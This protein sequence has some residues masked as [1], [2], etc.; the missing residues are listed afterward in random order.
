MRD[1]LHRS[2]QIGPTKSRNQLVSL[3]STLGATIAAMFIVGALLL[4]VSPSPSSGSVPRCADVQLTAAAESWIGA[5][6]SD[7]FTVQIAN[8]SAKSCS[9]GGFAKLEFFNTKSKR[10]RATVLHVGSMQYAT[11][12]PKDFV[13][14][15][16]TVASF[17]VSYTGEYNPKSDSPGE[18]V[19]RSMSLVLPTVHPQYYGTF[20]V[21]TDLDLC[22]SDWTVGLTPLEFGARVRGP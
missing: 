20:Y 19:A 21:P 8:Q 1:P 5:G 18:C 17:A 16:E 10:I 9:L 15:P 22:D 13:L 2:R 4:V 6:G 14:T 11:V 3:L 7:G 12:K